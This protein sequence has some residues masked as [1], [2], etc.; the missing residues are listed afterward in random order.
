MDS[1][2]GQARR[3]DEEDVRAY[4]MQC[5]RALLDPEVRRDRA[6]VAA[7]L[8]DDFEEFGASG[9]VWSKQ[10]ALDLLASEVYAPLTADQM[11]C[12]Q[13]AEDVALVTYRAVRIDEIAETRVETLRSSLW[14]RDSGN[15]RMRFHQGTRVP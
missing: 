5:E 11:R 12:A 2:I 9:R 10:T 3:P 8:A 7:L 13:I 4:L 15:W 1:T 6:R 14:V